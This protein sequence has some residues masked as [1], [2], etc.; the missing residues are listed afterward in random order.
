MCNW[1]GGG[2]ETMAGR[3][4]SNGPVDSIGAL[5]FRKNYGRRNEEAQW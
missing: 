2:T 5:E 4:R 1:R 3:A